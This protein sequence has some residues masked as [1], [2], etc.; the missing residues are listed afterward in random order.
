MII[1]ATKRAISR[2]SNLLPTK[3]SPPNPYIDVSLYDENQVPEN[4]RQA[5]DSLFPT[6]QPD[7]P[8]PPVPPSGGIFINIV[9]AYDSNALNDFYYI[10]SIKT[11]PKVLQGKIAEYAGYYYDNGTLKWD[12]SKMKVDELTYFIVFRL[13]MRLTGT[14]ETSFEES[15]GLQQRLDDCNKIRYAY[16]G[17]EGMEITNFNV[18][19]YYYHYKNINHPDDP[20]NLVS[21]PYE[22]F[23]PD[24]EDFQ[25]KIKRKIKRL[26][27]NGLQEIGDPI[28]ETDPII[29][30]RMVTLVDY[31]RI[32]CVI[33]KNLQK[34]FFS[35]PQTPFFFPEDNVLNNDLNTAFDDPNTGNHA[36]PF[37]F[38][39]LARYE[40][41]YLSHWMRRKRSIPHF[42]F[43][44]NRPIRCINS[45]THEITVD[46]DNINFG[47]YA[48]NIFIP[49]LSNTS[50]YYRFYYL[51][52]RVVEVTG[53]QITIRIYQ[54]V[55]LSII[56][57]NFGKVNFDGAKQ[58]RVKNEEGFLQTKEKSDIIYTTFPFPPD[59][60]DAY[61]PLIV[62]D[63]LY[64]Y[65]KNHSLIPY[66]WNDEFNNMDLLIGVEQ[67][68]TATINIPQ[69]LANINNI[70][71]YIKGRYIIKKKDKNDKD[72]YI[73]EMPNNLGDVITDHKKLILSSNYKP[74]NSGLTLGFGLDMG[75]QGANTKTLIENTLNQC[76]KSE[77]WQNSTSKYLLLNSKSD[78]DKGIRGMKRLE[79]AKFYWLHQHFFDNLNLQSPENGFN[80]AT[81]LQAFQPFIEEAYLNIL[82]NNL[83]VSGM[84]AEPNDF[85]IAI[86]LT[87]YYHRPADFSRNNSIT[88][89]FAK[90]INHHNL[91]KLVSAVNMITKGNTIKGIK[92]LLK[93]GI[94]GGEKLLFTKYLYTYYN[95]FHLNEI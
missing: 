22:P 1:V 70:E 48:D 55:N 61:Q 43:G 32:G 92:S 83:R 31:Y 53:T 3:V 8:A 56:G 79:A 47:S 82:L 23:L 7:P 42:P 64:I 72:K 51:S 63:E 93:N 49:N 10:P 57:K 15:Y 16:I 59:P 54:K 95:E 80:Y 26:H 75:Q 58:I 6:P 19:K 5:I 94:K 36:I 68:F 11:V 78:T 50:E 9:N 86:M 12:Y 13:T 25:P 30:K 45:S 38:Y 67:T 27:K 2:Y 14:K 34:M 46:W 89:A 18:K 17:Q 88:K 84:K 62:K 40:N 35:E 87:L 69:T 73:I 81:A 65:T 29:E 77:Y 37:S 76:V 24:D 52:P 44:T 20:A 71:Y 66:Y 91:K 41:P 39:L 21:T 33:H 60:S 90:A 4:F 74:N 28:V 85:E